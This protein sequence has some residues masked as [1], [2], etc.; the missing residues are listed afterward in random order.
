MMNSTLKTLLILCL[1]VTAS[2]TVAQKA[3]H[4]NFRNLI[5]MMPETN[6]A[7]AQLNQYQNE[8]VAKGESMAAD[9][10]KKYEAYAMKIQAGQIA[11]QEQQATEVA[12]GKERDAIVAYE[13]DVQQKMES[14][15]QELLKPIIEKVES[16]VT[17]V[18]KENG[19]ELIFDSSVLNA[20]LMAEESIDVT[21]LVKAKL[22]I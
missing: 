13:A 20:V 16:A 7:N 5:N 1:V 22:G 9:F 8:L 3:G 11:Q 10:Q 4:T 21:E 14:K 17:T 19:Y 12:L 6:T 18:A 2:N 15:R